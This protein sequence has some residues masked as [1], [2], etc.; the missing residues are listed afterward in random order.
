MP[1]KPAQ[2]LIVED[3]RESAQTIDAYLQN[4]TWCHVTHVDSAAEALCE[5]LTTRHHV[6]LISTSLPDTN[7]LT[8][9]R[10]LRV[11]NQCPVI[12]MAEDP[13]ADEVIEAMRLQV[14]DILI[15]PFEPSNLA[16][17]ACEAAQRERKHRRMRR[18]YRKLRRLSSRIVNERQDIQ[19]RM[20]LICKDFVQAYRRLAQKVAESGLVN[21]EFTE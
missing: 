4:A 7:Y 19:Q 14:T 18:G 6:I 13:S 17:V 9:V 2:I 1:K 15:K 20:D 5:E 21:S 12:L 3:D 8:L 11:S 10:E 16:E